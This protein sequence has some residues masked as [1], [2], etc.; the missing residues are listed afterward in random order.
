MWPQQSLNTGWHR[1]TFAY[2]INR[3]KIIIII[4]MTPMVARPS[5]QFARCF[6]LIN[7]EKELSELRYKLKV[8]TGGMLGSDYMTD[9]KNALNKGL[10][11]AVKAHARFVR[12]P[13]TRVCF[14]LTAKN[15]VDVVSLPYMPVT[16]MNAGL[17]LSCIASPAD[18]IAL[19]LM[20]D[21]RF[22][23][24]LIS[25]WVVLDWEIITR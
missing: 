15:M 8:H 6:H 16:E 3:P 1:V 20:F 14:K 4:I 25:R 11:N 7:H 19:L 2:I 10:R 24:V 9:V 18:F 12:K 21:F 22:R 5:F 23:F 17:I 13:A